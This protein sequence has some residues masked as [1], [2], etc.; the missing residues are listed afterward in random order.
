MAATLHFA[1][2]VTSGTAREGELENSHRQTYWYRS[3][4]IFFDT[5]LIFYRKPLF[6]QNVVSTAVVTNRF[7]NL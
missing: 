3:Y 6:N 5:F 2:S 7:E 1:L 4:G